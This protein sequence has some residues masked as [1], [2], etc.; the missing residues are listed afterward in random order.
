M[1]RL[2]LLA[3]GGSVGH[4]AP[5]FALAPALEAR[6]I[7]TR[8]AT[9]GE[10]K[11]VAWFP[12]GWPARFTVAAPRRPRSLGDLLRFPFR[13]AAAVCSARRLLAEERVAGVVALGG[14]P[15][16]PTV[17]AAILRRAPL[18]F[19]ASD[20]VPG[21][22]VRLF[23]P[24][25]RRIYVATEEGRAALRGRRGVVVTGAVVRP[26]IPRGRRDPARFGLDAGRRTLFVTG[27]SLGA[28]GLNEHVVH[29]LEAAIKKDPSV[30]RRFQVIHSVGGSGD[31]IAEAYA[32]AGVPAHVTPFL[33]DM[34]TAYKTADVVLC[35]SGAMTCAEL[36][37]T[38]TPA[39]FVPYPHHAD[40]QQYRNA[41]PL[42]ERGAAVVVEEADLSPE[43]FDHV[44]LALLADDVR[45]RAMG[46]RMASGFRDAGGR[47]ADDF[48]CCL[49]ACRTA[50][51]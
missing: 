51:R 2:V 5:G 27:G 35:R 3:G 25:A 8:F 40:R 46:E 14:W 13:M 37:A 12:V 15:C 30:A 1:T 26:E 21:L 50:R 6:G 28:K 29:G 49:G 33:R 16:V 42:A 9:P 11:E 20:A 39:V 36:E 34:G 48:L 32:A 45:L 18:A 38:G 31:G 43:R 17:F 47:I 22:V 4:L 24:F 19:V 44:V 41:A 10:A 7:S 23:A